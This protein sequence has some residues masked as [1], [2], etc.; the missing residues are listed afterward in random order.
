MK[1]VSVRT[2]VT[3]TTYKGL[4]EETEKKLSGFFEIEYEDV[5][6]KLS[7]EILIHESSSDGVS[8]PI[9]TGEILC[10]LRS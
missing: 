4:I 8:L 2:T 9:F 1:S 7:Y 5:K 6:D 3:S 10:K